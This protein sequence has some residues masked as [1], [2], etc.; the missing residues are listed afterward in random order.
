MTV[1]RAQNQSERQ[2]ELTRLYEQQKAKRMQRYQQ[3]GVNLYVKNLDAA[4]TDDLLRKQ[5]E[6]YGAITSSKVMCD[7]NNHSKG[8]GFVC[9]EKPDDATKAVVGMN[10]KVLGTKLLYVALAQRKEDRKAQL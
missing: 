8:F 9:F 7:E 4:I 5:F 6:S 2:A 10:N 3:Q 1:C